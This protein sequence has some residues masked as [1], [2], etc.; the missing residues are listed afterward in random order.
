LTCGHGGGWGGA[1]GRDLAARAE[2]LLRGEEAAGAE[3]WPPQKQFRYVAWKVCKSARLIFPE[4]SAMPYPDQADD[5]F[6]TFRV[7]GA[8]VTM[9]LL[10]SW[11]ED[12]LQAAPDLPPVAWE[13]FGA[14]QDEA[15]KLSEGL[16]QYWERKPKQ[17]RR[18]R[19][20]K[21]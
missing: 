11:L 14:R 7:F 18:K 1:R 2:A 12:F 8:A 19:G 17:Q 9:Y 21:D 6:F 15:R 20:R 16:R 4:M 10:E 13:H 3:E 5:H